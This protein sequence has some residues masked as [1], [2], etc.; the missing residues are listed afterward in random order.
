MKADSYSN[1]LTLN[2]DERFELIDPW[3]EENSEQLQ[4]LSSGI[5]MILLSVASGQPGLSLFS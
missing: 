4:L 1:I 2:S 5:F 3:M